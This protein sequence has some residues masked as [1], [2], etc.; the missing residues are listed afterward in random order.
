MKRWLVRVGVGACLVVASAACGN[1]TSSGAL[2]E[3]D[4]QDD[5]GLAGDAADTADTSDTANSGADG[6]ADGVAD[7]AD[8][9]SCPGIGGVVC[10][11]AGDVATNL[12]CEAGE[13]TCPKGY[14]KF[15]GQQCNGSVCGGPCSL[16]CA[17]V[18]PSPDVADTVTFVDTAADDVAPHDDADAAEDVAQADIAAADTSAAETLCTSTGGT[19]YTGQCCSGT[20]DFPGECA[21]GG[22]TCAPQ[23]L[24]DIHRCD[25]GMGKCFDPTVGCK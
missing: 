9:A 1:S 18:V 16:P 24:S 11:C 13:W 7:A 19:V 20:G 12:V 14:G 22:C 15:T 6:V 17:D 10:C 23:Y 3:S 2:P 25:C 4:V 21:I 8:T 5:S